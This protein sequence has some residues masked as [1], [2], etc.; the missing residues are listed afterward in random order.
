[1][2]ILPPELEIRIFELVV[3]ASPFDAAL[4]LS[5]MLV[6]RRVQIWYFCMP[7]LYSRL[8]TLMYLQGG[9]FRLSLS[10]VLEGEQLESSEAHS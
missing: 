9:A 1:M 4:R 3:R 5:L 6:A 2:S 8:L 10:C 7:V